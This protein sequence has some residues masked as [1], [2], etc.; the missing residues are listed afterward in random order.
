M[1]HTV[2][3]GTEGQDKNCIA[4]SD[5]LYRDPFSLDL[6]Y[7]NAPCLIDDLPSILQLLRD[8]FL[9]DLDKTTGISKN[10]DI[11]SCKLL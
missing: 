1:G 3:Y 10:I 5:N 4:L 11:F 7:Q 6:L 2:R 9:G 8:S